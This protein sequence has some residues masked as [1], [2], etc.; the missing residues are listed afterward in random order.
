MVDLMV[1]EVD[2]FT[3][4]GDWATQ[5]R[6]LGCSIHHVLAEHPALA[7]VYS[8]QVRIGPHS[9]QIMERGLKLL[10]QAGFCPPEAADAF[11]ALF[12]YTAGY[13][14][15]G[16]VD[17]R[18]SSLFQVGARDGRGLRATDPA[19]LGVSR[20]AVRR[21]TRGGEIEV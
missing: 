9:L 14:Q 21:R 15:M 3:L 5:L 18:D 10:L 6:A 16:R 11:F 7:Q 20:R 4:A 13:H 17:P 19:I 8:T 2:L 12:T 1:G